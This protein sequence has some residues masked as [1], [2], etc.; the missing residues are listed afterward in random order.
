MAVITKFFVVRNGVEI[1]KVF[2]NKKEAEAYDKMLEAAE[3]LSE[4]IKG[5]D[6]D[7]DID[8]KT[9]DDIS[10]FLAKKA[11]EVIQIIK[12]VKPYS[13][14]APKEKT[15]ETPKQEKQEKPSGDN[16]KAKTPAAKAKKK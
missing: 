11:P 1:D 4:L 6:V 13:S 7:I 15:K 3:N 12:G 16:K 2:E 14:P 9:I 8:D 10:I 5:S